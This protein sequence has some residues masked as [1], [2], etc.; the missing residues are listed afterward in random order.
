MW[1][2][3]ECVVHLVCAEQVLLVPC[4]RILLT[5]SPG[6]RAG[7]EGELGWPRPHVPTMPPVEDGCVSELF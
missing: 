3:L 1:Q 5:P 4:A 6:S 7:C 2:Q